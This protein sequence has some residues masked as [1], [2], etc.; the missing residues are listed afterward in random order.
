MTRSTAQ[1][2]GCLNSAVRAMNESSEKDAD[3]G[4]GAFSLAAIG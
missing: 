4:W 2:T 3:M 1:N